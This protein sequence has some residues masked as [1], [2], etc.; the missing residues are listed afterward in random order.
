M[1]P[2]AAAP[3]ACRRACVLPRPL[4]QNQAQQAPLIAT[5]GG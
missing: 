5:A 4:A 2:H 3:Q 1:R